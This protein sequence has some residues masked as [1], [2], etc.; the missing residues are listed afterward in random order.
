MRDGGT[1]RAGVTEA[2][3]CL[4]SNDVA[5]QTGRCRRDK[6]VLYADYATECYTNQHRG[7]EVAALLVIALFTA[8]LPA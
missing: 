4:T 7:F 6:A 2:V 8:G 1:R 5:M 3:G